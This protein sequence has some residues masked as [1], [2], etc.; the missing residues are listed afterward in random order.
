MKEQSGGP[1]VLTFDLGTQ[2]ARAM[3]VDP[4]GSILYKAQ[5]RYETP[6]VS[7]QP[8]WA[9]QDPDFYWRELCAASRELKEKAGPDWARA[10]AVTLTCIRDTCVCVDI[11][12]RPLRP[13]I[14]WLDKREAH[15]LPRIPAAGK[16]A[17]A[18]IG[19]YES[20][21]LQR[22]MS[23]C[24]WIKVNQPEIWKKTH[25]FLMLSAYLNYRLTGHY[26]DSCANLIG[27]IPFDSKERRWMR[28]SDLRRCIF[29]VEPEKLYS[30]VE[31]GE[32]IGFVHQ[33]AGEQTGIP[34]GMELIATGS[35]K[36]CETLGLS[37]T[38][39]D[40]AALSFGTTATVQVTTQS[41]MEPLPFIP[42]YPAVLK[43]AYNPEVQIYRG[44]WLVSWFKREFA[45]KEMAEAR[46]K[47][48]SAEQLL[49][50]RLAEVPPGC[51]G[52]LFQPYFTPGIAMPTAR[53][54]I[55]G[56]SDRHTRIHLYRAIIEGV[57]YAL[58]DGLRTLEKRGG[59]AVRELYAAGG[60]AQSDEICQITANMFGLPVHR[61]QTHEASGLG[62]SMV[63]FAAKGVYPDMQA[64]AQ[65]MVRV[66]DRFEPEAA[67]HRL[68]EALYA[69]VF[70]KVFPRLL[71]LY[72]KEQA[73]EEQFAAPAAEQPQPAT[74]P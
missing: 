3:L 33:W 47:G 72:K 12:G 31:P 36:G 8:D 9:E 61:I 21:K 6:Y 70:Q 55:V 32:R 51:E 5:R 27:H 50:R 71:P 28:M 29:E 30:V 54:S 37:C 34:E 49:N 16:A 59:F 15:G 74:V 58:L 23:A 48:V 66:K 60:G 39:P 46:Q 65:A 67:Q 13:A 56:F 7:P 44:Y 69:Q 24:N 22:R 53:G 25:K 20:V 11:D 10:I 26:V 40:K 4:A 45:A 63:A 73:V 42:A 64:A 57:N 41:Y 68:Y 1:L 17:F 35:D 18:A 2:S 38:G 52:L 14:L 19:M 62:S 43:G